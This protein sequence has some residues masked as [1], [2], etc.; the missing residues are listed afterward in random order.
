MWPEGAKMEYWSP[1]KKTK[2]GRR[3]VVLESCP[4][5]YEITKWWQR[6]RG[7]HLFRT[8]WVTHVKVRKGA[9]VSRRQPATLGSEVRSQL[10]VK[11]KGR[12][13]TLHTGLFTHQPSARARL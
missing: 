10:F 5:V 3:Q 6:R 12:A 7:S 1:Q 4:A 2:G 11:E 9:S 13:L 8:G